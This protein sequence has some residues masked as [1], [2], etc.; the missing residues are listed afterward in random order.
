MAVT[1]GYATLTETKTHL[2]ITDSTDDTPLEDAIETASR[3][4]DKHTGRRF[5]KDSSGVARTFSASW[6]DCLYIPDLVSVTSVKTDDN[7]DRTYETTW[8]STDYDL[9]PTDGIMDGITGWPY[10]RI[11]ART[12]SVSLSRTFPTT[13]LGVE[14]T[15]VWGWNAVPDD[16][17]TACLLLTARL[18]RRK[19]APFGQSGSPDIGV[20][21]LPSQD[22]D[23]KRLLAPYR[24]ITVGAV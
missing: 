24:R 5:W 16:I 11:R 15:G 1:N 6:S 9:E 21:T 18:F 13:R 10:T 7:D 17:K 19:D 2:G 14:I 12:D 3:Q 22:P 23:V 20:V 8:A 4:I